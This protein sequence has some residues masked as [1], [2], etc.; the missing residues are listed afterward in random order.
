MCITSILL[1][2]PIP[3]GAEPKQ[4]SVCFYL[5]VA[6]RVLNELTQIGVGVKGGEDSQAKGPVGNYF[7]QAPFPITRPVCPEWVMVD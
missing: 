3:K 7:S 1:C 5:K 4:W 2:D 6:K